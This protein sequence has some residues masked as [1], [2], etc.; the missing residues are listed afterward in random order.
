MNKKIVYIL[1]AAGLL[2]AGCSKKE[3]KADLVLDNPEMY[4]EIERDPELARGQETVKESENE[5]NRKEVEEL[6][7]SFDLDYG[8]IGLETVMEELEKC[9]VSFAGYYNQSEERLDVILEDGTKLL[10]FDTSDSYTDPPAYELMMEGD[11]FNHNGFQENYLKAYDVITDEYYYPDFSERIWSSEEL[12]GFNQTDLSIARN[13]IFARHGRKFNDKFLNALFL[14]KSWYEPEYGGVEFEALQ[15]ELLSDIEKEN[16]KTVMDFEIARGYRKNGTD[17]EGLLNL[18][19]LD[20]DGDGKK[21]QI[22]YQILDQ[23]TEEDWAEISKISLSVRNSN[24]EEISIWQEGDAI[25]DKCYV[26][27]M[28][29]IHYFLIVAQNGLSADFVMTFYV[30]EEGKLKEAG[31][32][33]SDTRELDVYA[34]RLEAYEETYHFQCQPVKF[35]YHLVNGK[36]EKQEK[37]FYDY[38]G[39]TATVLQEIP[40][41]SEK[42]GNEADIELLAGDAV[43]VIGGDLKEWVQLKKVSTGEMGWIKVNV[44]ECQLPDGNCIDSRHLFEGLMFYG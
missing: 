34:D 1:M 13:Q 10:F 44:T 20:L 7:A 37:D 22:I 35:E 8:R 32:I 17:A 26:A 33:Y 24:G 5:V 42:N 19:S 18:S 16:L 38:R 28:D 40:L 27:S 11:D 9:D 15:Q 14:Q 31:N 39:N 41:Y 3:E 43:Q 36:L 25:H 30:Y 12:W 21:E 23:E 2:L 29:G 4:E 6:P